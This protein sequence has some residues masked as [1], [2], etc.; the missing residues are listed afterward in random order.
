M[1]FII[2]ILLSPV[3]YSC[4]S[5]LEKNEYIQSPCN[6]I[7]YQNLKKMKP[8]EMSVNELEY[9]KMKE[10]ECED[11]TAEQGKSIHNIYTNKQADKNAI[12][13]VLG[14]IAAIIIVGILIGFG[15]SGWG[16]SH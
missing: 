13:W 14:G 15:L 16:S 4:T 9:L 5:S 8:N 10:R 2:C 12:W 11:Y 6:D 3:F 7:T 1:K